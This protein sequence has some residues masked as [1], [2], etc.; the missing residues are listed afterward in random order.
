MFEYLLKRLLL[1]FPT[2]FGVSVIIFAMMRLVPGDPVTIMLGF[3]YRPE[4]AEEFERKLGL[5]Q[6]LVVQY[7]KWV[8]RL[9]TGDWGKSVVTG[10]YVRGEILERLPVT[11]E[12]IALAMV[13]AVLISIPAGII[14]AVKPNSASDHGLMTFAMLGISAPEFFTGVLF[15]L[16][17]SFKLGW[18]PAAGYAPLS[19]GI[20]EHL[21]YMILPAV[22]LGFPRAAILARLVRASMLEIVRQDYITTARAKG[23]S[24]WRVIVSHALRNAL[25]PPLSWA[26]LQIGYLV[27]GSVVV[28]IVFLLPGMAS[29]GMDGIL[30]RDYPSVQG[31]VLVITGIFVLLSLVVDLLYLVVDPRIRIQDGSEKT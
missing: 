13:F 30:G 27:G 12:L 26:G 21:Q 22:T 3:E 20:W 11:L 17:F 6:P 25:I 8:G 31:F 7:A 23:L 5:D 24:E 18:L 16:I 29:F 19:A 9:L 28:E 4:L 1:L 14:S 10:M 2:L 15:M